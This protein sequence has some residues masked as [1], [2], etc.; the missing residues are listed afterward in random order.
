MSQFVCVRFVGAQFDRLPYL[1]GIG[2]LLRVSRLNRYEAK[3]YKFAFS[4]YLRRHDD[5]SHL[6]TFSSLRKVQLARA[7][8]APEGVIQRW[9]LHSWMPFRCDP[10]VLRTNYHFRY[11]PECLRYGYHTLL[12]QLPWIDRCPWHGAQLR[13]QCRRCGHPLRLDGLHNLWLGTCRCGYDHV[14][15]RL[16][17]KGFASTD[18]IERACNSYLDWARV[19]RESTELLAPSPNVHSIDA[20]KDSFE[21]PIVLRLRRDQGREAPK[22]HVVSARPEPVGR[23]GTEDIFSTLTKLEGLGDLRAAMIEAPGRLAVRISTVAAELARQL[24][25]RSLSK[26]EMSLF[27]EPAGASADQ[28][29]VPAARKSILEIRSLPLA[30]VGRRAYLDLHCI[31][32]VTRRVAYSLWQ[33]IGGDEVSAVAQPPMPDLLDLRIGLA[34]VHELIA[35]GYAEGIRIALGHHVADLYRPGRNRPHLSEPWVLVHKQTGH[36]IRIQ[37]VWARLPYNPD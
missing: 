9:E 28:G 34:A 6:M 11:C 5:L 12:H 36:P 29:F 17:V 33:A 20:L 4:M 13:P 23:S 16:A 26:A 32:P 2:A 7:L 14:D 18:E 25:A 30:M 1:S 31:H 22:C 10:G 19:S 37:I 35:R 27:L 21:V 3:D 24:P 15:E 8:S